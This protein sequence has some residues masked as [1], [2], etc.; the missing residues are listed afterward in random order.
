MKSLP[1]PGPRKVVYSNPYQRVY[2]QIVDFG[3]F[4]NEYFV[5]D[6]GPR[7]GVLVEKS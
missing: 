3:K 1:Q 5:T 6:Y 7:A 4:S 2:R